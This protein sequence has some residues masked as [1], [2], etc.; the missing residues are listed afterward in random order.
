MRPFR[1]LVSLAVLSVAA[2]GLVV[3]ASADTPA[4]KTQCFFSRDFEN[5][6]APDD[7]TINIRVGLSKYYRLELAGRCSSLTWPDSHLVNHLRGSDTICSALDWDL[8]VS[9]GDHGISQA[10]IVKQMTQLTPE[11]AGAIP[12]KFKP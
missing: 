11:E 1:S 3:P 12:R 10:C 6:K 8:H 2:A 4:R 7:K 5:W 9:Q